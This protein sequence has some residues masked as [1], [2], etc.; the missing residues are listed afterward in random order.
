M[1]KVDGGLVTNRGLEIEVGVDVYLSA[2]S[3]KEVITLIIFPRP[4]FGDT[5]WM[6]VSDARRSA[7]GCKSRTPGMDSSLSSVVQD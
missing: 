7:K 5:S 4:G 1:L 2:I 6:L 3:I